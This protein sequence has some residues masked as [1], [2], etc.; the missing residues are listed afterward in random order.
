MLM[1]L[2]PPETRFSGLHSCCRLA[3]LHSAW[4]GELQKLTCQVT[5]HCEKDILHGFMVI[6]GRQICHQSKERMHLPISTY[7]HL[8]HLLTSAI[9]RMVSQL[10]WLTGQK[11]CLWDILPHFTLLLVSGITLA[12]V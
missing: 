2:R 5:K 4:C 7:Y 3:C 10:W 6:Q 8:L 9:S 1:N 12:N 11:N